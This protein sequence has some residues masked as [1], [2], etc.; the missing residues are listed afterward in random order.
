VTITGNL[1]RNFWT[2]RIERFS[3]FAKA[4]IKAKKPLQAPG[5]WPLDHGTIVLATNP[6]GL[7]ENA[8]EE[9]VVLIAINRTRRFFSGKVGERLAHEPALAYVDAV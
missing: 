1:V 3:K 8:S 4:A 7:P 5:E 6:N 9:F 2:D